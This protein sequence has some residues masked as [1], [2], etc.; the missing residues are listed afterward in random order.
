M[1]TVIL[2]KITNT[3]DD[4]NIRALADAYSMC[5]T[6]FYS[7]LRALN[8]RKDIT[9]TQT[10]ENGTFTH[11][12]ILKHDTP[13]D[14]EIESDFAFFAPLARDFRR[15]AAC[16]AIKR[17]RGELSEDEIAQKMGQDGIGFRGACNALRNA[18]LVEYKMISRGTSIAY[19][20]VLCLGAIRSRNE[21]KIININNNNI[22][23]LTC[24]WARSRLYISQ[25]THN[26]T[27]FR[28]QM[29]KIYC[30]R[31]ALLTSD[32][33]K[34]STYRF[35]ALAR[36]CPELL[37]NPKILWSQ[38]VHQVLYYRGKM[39]TLKIINM[40]FKLIETKRWRIPYGWKY[41]SN[42]GREYIQALQDRLKN[43]E[44]WK[45]REIESQRTCNKDLSFKGFFKNAKKVVA[46]VAETA[47]Q[48]VKFSSSAPQKINFEDFEALKEK[49]GLQ[50]RDKP[51]PLLIN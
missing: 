21:D 45:K 29:S 2:Q 5:Y 25:P 26:R 30:D 15:A 37:K 17:A 27:F 10:D 41:L 50:M 28:I 12:K 42:V 40:I 20:P 8:F 14:D 22:N 31:S 34:L 18:G 24:A 44:S 48:S 46:R 38:I 43:H 13:S 51:P 23:S 35:Q 36:K 19:A 9:F 47:K 3:R 39:P 6:D 7:V 49:F 33:I 16:I 32:E 11:F 1:H 4:I